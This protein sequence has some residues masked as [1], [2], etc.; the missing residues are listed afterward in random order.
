MKLIL[1]AQLAA[2]AAPAIAVDLA[3][4]AGQHV[5]YSYPG[6]TPPE[7]LYKLTSEGKVGGLIIFKENVNSNL[8]AIMD[9]FQALYKA[10]PAYNGHPMIITTDQEG[11]NV[12]RVPGGP[13]QSARQIGDSSTP[14]QAASQAGRDAAAALK[15]QKINGNLAPVLDIY[16]EEGNFIDEFGRSF[17]NNTE[18]VTS[19]GS[20]FAISQS[21]SGVLSTVKH[22]PGLGAAK[23]GENTDL[24][25]IKIDLSL[26]EIRAFDEV[27]YHTA[28]RNGVDMIMT[29][30]ALYPALDA[31]YPAGLSRKWTTGELRTRLGYKGVI[32]T[33]AIEA[34]SLKSF[35]NDGQRGVLAAKAGVDILLASGRNATQGE[36]IVNEIVAALKKGTLSMTEF[37]E[38]TKR[39]QALQSR[40]LA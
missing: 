31:K 6:L 4:Q 32:I 33:D 19:C 13:S 22:F 39:I 21:R 30:W 36:A 9:K 28:I 1:F 18:I 34:G 7:S 5:M 35:G 40:L 12:R 38:S 26:D 27:P 10:S 29:S 20:A 11:G 15:A 24:V 2:V 37:Q 17:G 25:P 14:M 8:P 16:R 23:K 3:V